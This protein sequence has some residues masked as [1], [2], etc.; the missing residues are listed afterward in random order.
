RG[1]RLGRTRRLRGLGGGGGRGGRGRVV[2]ERRLPRGRSR[3]VD[4]TLRRGAG[5]AI[6]ER[7]ETRQVAEGLASVLD[8]EQGAA[9]V[10]GR[11]RGVDEA[12]VFLD[13]AGQVALV[14]E[15]RSEAAMRG[16]V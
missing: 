12:R 5:H 1:G 14:R 6:D 10:V 2:R 13:R 11:E 9:R 4:A 15:R 3:P 8:L 16:E 7:D